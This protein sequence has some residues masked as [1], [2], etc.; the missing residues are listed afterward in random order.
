MADELPTTGTNKVVKRT[1]SHQ[2]LRRDLVGDDVLWV[3]DRGSPSYREFTADDELALRA[4]L[5]AAG[6]G[7]FWEL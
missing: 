6:R 2:K 1:L 5:D 7:R 4:A 3:R